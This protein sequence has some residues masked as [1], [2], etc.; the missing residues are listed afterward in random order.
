MGKG[1]QNAANL[2]V[3]GWGITIVMFLLFMLESNTTTDILNVSIPALAAENGWNSGILLSA[4]TIAGWCALVTSFLIGSVVQKIGPT[5]I[6]RVSTI[7]F[8]IC[9]FFTG[10]AP[11]TVCYIIL[12]VLTTILSNAQLGIAMFAVVANWFPTKK[13][14]VMGFATMGMTTSTVVLLSIVTAITEKS[15]IGQA[16]HFLGILS[17]VVAVLAFLIVRDTPESCGLNPDND[18]SITP[19]MRELEVQKAKEIMASSP[20]TV[21][22][23][24]RTK[25]VWQIS[26]MLGINLMAAT[27]VMSQFV[28]RFTSI[29]WDVSQ[30]TICLVLG[31]LIGLPVS[32]IWGIIDAKIG[33]AKVTRILLCVSAAGMLIMIAA[34]QSFAMGLIAALLFMC[35][36]AGTNNMFMSYTSSVF[37]RYDFAN[38]NRLMFP[39]YNAI[40]FLAFAVMGLCLNL[41]GGFFCKE[42]SILF[43][44][45][46]V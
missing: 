4:S 5:K 2:G 43:L 36:L 9:V 20:W 27:A 29:G 44:L 11:N 17:L 46:S 16:Y 15:G 10:S 23:L 1:K 32:F 38:A 33:S 25:Q 35:A 24:L 39:I 26:V 19:E 37:G 3:R 31:S 42:T 22:K 18:P 34:G 28:A 7:L 45:S 6:I 12:I 13:G 21:Q 14:V 41:F 8:A 30:A 40:R